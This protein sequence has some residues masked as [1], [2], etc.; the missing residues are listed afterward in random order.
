[1]ALEMSKRVGKVALQ[2]KKHNVPDNLKAQIKFLLD[3]SG[4]AMPFYHG[5]RSDMQEL[6]ER[7]MAVALRLDA[8][9]LLEVTSFSDKAHKHG[10]VTEPEIYTYIQAR[11]IPEAT[12]AGT[13]RGGTNYAKAVSTA[14]AANP[15]AK[16]KGFFTKMFSK[17]EVVYPNVHFFVSDGQDMGDHAEFKRLVQSSPNDYFMLIGVGNVRDFGLMQ[18]AADL[19]DNVGFVHFDDLK[20]SD[21]EMYEQ[22]LQKEICDWLIARQ[23][24]V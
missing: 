20:I 5:P 7:L 11:F 16:A 12:Q 1:M 13:W 8:D 4:S 9:G 6:T 14:L 19:Y 23:P 24:A 21:D 10:D 22:I 2:L 18:E 3:V 15:V 17:K